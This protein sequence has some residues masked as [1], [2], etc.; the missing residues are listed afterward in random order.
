MTEYTYTYSSPLKEYFQAFLSFKASKYQ[1]KFSYAFLFKQIDAY[2]VE[3][4]YQKTYIDREIYCEWLEE[5]IDRVRPATSYR[6]SSMMRTFLIFTTK[7]GNECY[8]PSPRKEPLR[9]YVPHVFSHDEMNAIFDAADKLRLQNR[10]SHNHL[11][12]IPA[13]FRLLYSTG[14]RLGEALELRNKDVDIKAHVIKLRYTKNWCDRLAPINESLGA[15]LEEYLK[16]RDRIP[17]DG[18]DRPEGYFFCGCRGQKCSQMTV[19]RW[20]H[21]VRKEAGIPY[22]GREGGPNVHCFR[23]TACV[24]ALMKMVES[25]KDPFCC[26]PTL[27]AFMGHRDVKDTEYYLHLSEELYPEIVHYE[28]RISSGVND[29][30]R[31]A[32]RQYANENR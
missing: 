3:K 21:I 7:M 6:E 10:C 13:L 20:F 25:G 5:R 28:Q 11:H 26:L 29:V 12:M 1:D 4:G 18:I 31:N 32:T 24:H 22:Y 2:L 9:T 19:R 8:I 16:N 30:I 15:V 14:M 17:T 23:H 27:T